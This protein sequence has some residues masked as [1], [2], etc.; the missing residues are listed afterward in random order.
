MQKR[1]EKLR[2]I[3]GEENAALI[4][5]RANIFYYSGFTSE[6]AYLLI[7]PDSA[8]IYTDSRYTVQAKLQAENFELIE[9]EK[10]LKRLLDR[11]A[12][13]S[14][15]I[16]EDECVTVSMLKKLTEAAGGIRLLGGSK[17]ISLPRCVKDEEEIK[18]IAEAERLGDVAFS[19]ILDY[20]KAGMT[21]RE[22]ALELEFFMRRYG[23]SS[24]SFE[25]IAAS[26]E[27]SAMPHGTASDRMLKSGDLFTLD[28]G[29]VLDGY[30]SDMTRTVCIG[31]P[32]ER[33]REIYNVVLK[34][35][36]TALSKIHAGM[37]CK[38]ADKAARDVIAEA[39]YGSFFGHSLGHSVGVEIHE[40]PRLSPKSEDVLECGNV[41]TVEPGIYI[42]GFGG[43]RIEDVVAVSESGVKNLTH[44]S[45]ELIIING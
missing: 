12:G 7:T 13:C 27:R 14:A 15:I 41:V 26:G 23:A 17:H 34:A 42:E 45:K 19:H 8:Y 20:I 40:L 32:D 2:K 16:M 29:C 3:I 5:G 33:S 6:D 24:L 36:E 28:F 35:Q 22:I 21:E 44:S 39:G 43:V 9:S 1:I 25:T 4:S 18:K 11:A 10:G 38:D 37:S 30:C 31:N